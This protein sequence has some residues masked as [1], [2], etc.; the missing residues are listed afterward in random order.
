VPYVVRTASLIAFAALLSVGCAQNLQL[1]PGGV[2]VGGPPLSYWPP[3]DSTWTWSGSTEV[4]PSRLLGEAA[5]QVAVALRSAGYADQRWYAIGA[6][7]AHGFVVTTRLERVQDDGAPGEM[8]TRWSS[9]FSEAGNL[10]WLEGARETR[11]PGRGRYRV[12]LVAFTDL[13]IG[14]TNRA[15]RRSEQ[16]WMAERPD[17]P[18]TELPPARRVS[19]DYRVGVYVYE[20]Q[21]GAS[22]REGAFVPH[23]EAPAVGPQM[24]VPALSTLLGTQRPARVQ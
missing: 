8:G 20:Y 17:A 9:S 22:D 7:Y 3:P 5:S 19:S 1:R 12:L 6:R 18:S 4:A 2:V 16:T 24:N 10:L 14:A 15:Q 11:L 13:P 23:D 21:S